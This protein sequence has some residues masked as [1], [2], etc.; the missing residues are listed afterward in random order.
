M[1]TKGMVVLLLGKGVKGMGN[2][3][4]VEVGRCIMCWLKCW[5]RKKHLMYGFTIHTT[6]IS[7]TN[8]FWLYI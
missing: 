5:H 2:E 4:M 7:S 3:M 1:V 6:T 8:H